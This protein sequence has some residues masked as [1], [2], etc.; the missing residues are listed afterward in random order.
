METAAADLEELRRRIAELPGE[1]DQRIAMLSLPRPAVIDLGAAP[2][3]GLNGMTSTSNPVDVELTPS[4]LLT[5]SSV[6]SRSNLIVSSHRDLFSPVNNVSENVVLPLR[7]TSLLS[8]ADNLSNDQ[9]AAAASTSGRENRLKCRPAAYDGRTATW[10]E[11]EAQFAIL[12]E[13][14]D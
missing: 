5:T 6:D 4:V 1:I 3:V 8:V 2:P 10:E 7:G 9:F 13:V 14:N 11:Y 12:S